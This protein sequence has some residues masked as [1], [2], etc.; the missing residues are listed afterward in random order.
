VLDEPLVYLSAEQGTVCA[1]YLL[2]KDLPLPGW[3]RLSLVARALEHGTA[4]VAKTLEF[5]EG[6]PWLSATEFE[7]VHETWRFAEPRLTI[8]GVEYEDSGAYY[9]QHKS[10]A[11]D[12]SETANEQRMEVMCTALTAK[13][14][15]SGEARALLVASHPHRLLSIKRDRFWGFDAELGGKNMLGELLTQ[16]RKGYVSEYA[17]EVNIAGQCCWQATTLRGRRRRSSRPVRG[18]GVSRGGR[19]KEARDSSRANLV[20]AEPD[21]G[22]EE[23]RSLLEGMEVNR[24][25]P[26]CKW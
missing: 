18:G 20:Q 26:P 6:E 1:R 16:L 19:A 12:W 10:A 15:A 17:S 8:D 5:T 2:L 24:R 23:H 13:F 14:A 21:Q 4:G 9:Q 25:G 7:N 22:E 11:G 3:V